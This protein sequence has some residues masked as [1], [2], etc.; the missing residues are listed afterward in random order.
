MQLYTI[1]FALLSQPAPEGVTGVEEHCFNLELS[2][3]ELASGGEAEV[4]VLEGS[5]LR[6]LADDNENA[7][8]GRISV[9][10][11]DDKLGYAGAPD[12][13]YL[14]LCVPHSVA[15][16]SCVIRDEFLLF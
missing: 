4:G 12:L 11:L 15:L 3:L 5:R 13:C 8:Y 10:Q 6:F 14:C 1:C 7:F 16:Q 9:A 2:L